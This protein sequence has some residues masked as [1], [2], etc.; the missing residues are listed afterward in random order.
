M[1]KTLMSI[2]AALLFLIPWESMAVQAPATT[3]DGRRLTIC[4][5][6]ADLSAYKNLVVT[7]IGEYN[8]DPERSSLGATACKKPFTTFGYEW[9]S[10]LQLRRVGGRDT[11]SKVP[12]DP[13]S[14]SI[15]SFDRAVR[16]LTAMTVQGC[17]EITGM[18]Q[19][20]EDYTP[21][22]RMANGKM[23]GLGFGHMNALPAQLIIK[24]VRVLS[25]QA[26][27]PAT[28]CMCCDR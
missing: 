3:P 7:V 20:R 25:L 10:A 6:M 9:P 2:S 22:F 18:V 8:S 27:N 16:S 14:A 13:D 26:Y 17:L 4:E 19:V 1:I 21:T 12:F 24:S 15:E 11:P 28:Q 23:R 5:L